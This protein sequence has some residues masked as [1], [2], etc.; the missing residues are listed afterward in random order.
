MSRVPHGQGALA[1]AKLLPKATTTPVRMG[2]KQ[3]RLWLWVR[4]MFPILHLRAVPFLL[5]SR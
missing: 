2:P 4:R 1:Y 5:L 3:R